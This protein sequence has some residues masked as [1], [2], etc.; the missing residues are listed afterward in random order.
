MTP[1]RLRLI[2]NGKAAS[3]E[4]LRE[5]INALRHTGHRVEV[6]VTWEPGD[7]RH[8]AATADGIDVVVAA[9]GDGTINEVVHG[10]MDWPDETRPA[11]GVIPLGTAND[12]ARGCAIPLEIPAALDLCAKGTPRP[13]DVGKANDRWFINA[14]SSGFGAEVTANTPTEL[15]RL[16][17]GAAY[18]LMG[19]LLATSF[20]PHEGRLVLPEGE[21]QNRS[22]V[23]IVSNGRQAG[24]GKPVAPKALLNDG[25]L[26]I[27]VIS[28]IPA[29][30]LL[31]AMKELQTPEN[32]G[33][34]IFY[35]QVP[36]AEFHPTVP[37][38]VNLDGEP[39]CFG[40]VRYEAVPGAIRLIA[41][42][43][44]PELSPGPG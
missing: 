2:L 27:L 21:F 34:Y 35:R 12:F 23:T 36:W 22:V 15:K 1:R 37:L 39:A 28:E 40:H 4:E 38:A 16:L 42:A 44:C 25:L 7:A 11:L 5:S 31:Q 30:G 20:E 17:G 43:D 18:T 26:D 8:H 29:T 10:L 13:I 41:P 24:G 32:D 14:A 33:E 3:S 6:R 19:P 9:G